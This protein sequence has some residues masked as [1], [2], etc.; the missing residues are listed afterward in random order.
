MI[1]LAS[2]HN[3]GPYG[4]LVRARRL[5]FIGAAWAFVCA[6]GHSDDGIAQASKMSQ[7]GFVKP[8]NLANR[9]EA[10]FST[11]SATPPGIAVVASDPLDNLIDSGSIAGMS[12]DG[13]DIGCRAANQWIPSDILRARARML[14]QAFCEE[15]GCSRQA[16]QVLANFL[17]MQAQHQ[18]DIGAA[19]AMRAYYTR[20]AL[21]EQRSILASSLS[22][23]HSEE[24]AQA[25]IQEGGLAAGTDLS[26]F[27]RLRI[28][29]TDKRLVMESQERQLR[30]LLSQLTGLN[31]A[32]DEVRHEQLEVF[33]ASL[34]CDRLKAFALS[35]R[36]DLRAW[37]YLSRHINEESAPIFAGMLTTLVGG[38]GLPIPTI[39]GLKQLL[40]PPDYSC[41]A[42]NMKHEVDLTVETHRKWICQAVDE[43]CN[44]LLLA[45]QRIHL[46]QQMVASWE[47]RLAQLDQMESQG[48]GQAAESAKARTE[49]LKAKS[50][51]VSRRL[52][53]KLAEIDLSEACGGLSSRCCNGQPWLM[54]GL[55]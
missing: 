22:L 50:E 7:V 52:D 48:E 32:M 37:I 2:S 9:G 6:T 44:K 19:S 12:V 25:A 4:L 21:V 35:M 8:A 17:C 41:L 16:A 27:E 39:S 45:Y 34:D 23:V 3:P 13:R 1:V 14:V 31:Y 54:T 33:E 11:H 30:C 43:K 55:E 36:H 28:E 42:A 24:Q 15:D 5:A 46:A 51:E 10:N 49:L 29:I 53:A 38:Y 26:S 18:E 40:C 20:V 47:E